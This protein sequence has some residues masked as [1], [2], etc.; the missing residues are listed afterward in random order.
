VT[1]E[2]A[3]IN[4]SAVTLATDS[5]VTLTVRGADKIYNCAD[6]LFELSDKDPMGIMIYNNL[7]YMGIPL[8][9]A[10]KQFR[11]GIGNVHYRSVQDA[12]D[13]FF[14]YLQN[15]L[16]PTKELQ[17]EHVKSILYPV[18]SSIREDYYSDAKRA[19]DKF[20]NKANF[21]NVFTEVVDRHI[22]SLELLPVADC[23]ANTS[24]D[25]LT[26]TYGDLFRDLIREEV[27]N[28]LPITD[29]HSALL[30]RICILALL[31]EKYSDHLTGLVF[32]GFGQNEMFPSLVA[33]EIDGIIADRLK[34][35]EQANVSTSRSKITG[36]ILPFA[37]RE[38]VDR[39][40]YGI[41]PEF[42][43]G[44]EYFLKVV[45]E[46]TGEAIV[47]SLPKA[48]KATKTKLNKAVEASAKSSLKL[49]REK[50]LESVKN[51]FMRQVQDMIF[52]MPKQE[53]ATLAQELINL[54]SVKRKFSSGKESVGGPIDVAVISRIDG[55]VWVRRKHYFDPSLNPRYFHRKFNSVSQFSGDSK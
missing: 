41:D 1:A 55:F 24:E 6:K 53:L 50:V 38:M 21:P 52:L 7:E 40:L 54:T 5:A 44:I 19:F 3:I 30:T 36:E 34:K 43:Q 33:Y 18:I 2:I 23:F 22:A 48:S 8:E 4:R 14:G 9:V 42:E 20:K 11:Q 35:R 15:E 37:Q 26:S 25:E 51:R 32:A 27:S 28:H 39:F 46:A 12:A 17:A 16:A 45:I 10:I 49:W 13:A 47:D 31:R 29:E